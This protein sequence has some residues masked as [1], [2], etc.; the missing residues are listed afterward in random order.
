MEIV[1]PLYSSRMPHGYR[2]RKLWLV[3]TSALGLDCP[4]AFSH[5]V[6]VEDVGPEAPPE[7]GEVLP[8]R[9]GDPEVVAVL[10]AAEDAPKTKLIWVI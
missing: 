1:G 8:V 7:G 6:P 5:A 9:A 2:C 4:D 10:H 3:K